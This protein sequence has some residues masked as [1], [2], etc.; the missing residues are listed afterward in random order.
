MEQSSQQTVV[1][2]EATPPGTP[3]P[4]NLGLKSFSVGQNSDLA[5]E[6]KY[7]LRYRDPQQIIDALVTAIEFERIQDEKK[8]NV[9]LEALDIAGVAHPK[10]GWAVKEGKLALRRHCRFCHLNYR[11]VNNA[12]DACC[13]EDMEGGRHSSHGKWEGECNECLGLMY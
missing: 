9:I 10:A 8:L 7:T 11:E 5:K 6:V 3:V 1:M 12:Y 13:G 4:D 2:G